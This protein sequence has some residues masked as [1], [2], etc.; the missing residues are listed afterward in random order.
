M[1]MEE[2][3]GLKAKIKTISKNLRIYEGGRERGAFW[4]SFQSRVKRWIFLVTEIK[5]K[6]GMETQRK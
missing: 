1:Q 3:G 2:L 5:G 6:D 4:V